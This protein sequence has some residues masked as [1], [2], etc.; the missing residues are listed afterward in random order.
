MSKRHIHHPGKRV[1]AYPG[2]RVSR[3]QKTLSKNLIAG[4]AVI[5]LATL[6]LAAKTWSDL[7]PLPATLLSADVRKP[8][9][10]DRNGTPLNITYQNRWNVHDYIELHEMPQFLQQ[11][12][13]VAEDK[14]FFEHGGVDWLARWHAAW[15]NMKALRGVRGASTITEQSVRMIHQRPRTLWSR[16][17]EGFEA[18]QLEKQ[19]SKAEILEFYLNQ[20]PYTAKRRGVAQA[21]RYY[22]DRSP[23]TLS[24]KEMM[25]LAVLVRSPSRLDLYRDPARVDGP[26]GRLLDQ[27]SRQGVLSARS[28]R[29]IAVSRLRLSGVPGLPVDASHFVRYVQRSNNAPARRLATTLDGSLQRHAQSV[30]DGRIRALRR[31]GVTHGA[32]LAV[33]HRSDEVLVWVNGGSEKSDIDAVLTLRQPGSALKPFVYA[34]ALEKGWT[35]ATLINDSPLTQSVGYGLHRYQNYSRKHYGAVRLRD[36]L[37]NSLN[38]PAVRA[39]QFVGPADVLAGFRRLGMDNLREHPDFYGDGIA[40]GNGEVSLLELVRAYAVLARQGVYRDLRT[41]SA[42]V[43]SA[44]RRVFSP[45]ASALIANILADP[46]ARSLEFGHS[47]LLNLPIQTAVKTGTSSDFRDAWTVGF[48]HRYVVGVWMGN[49]DYRAMDGITG[50]R[51]PASVMRAVFAELNRGLE[52]RPLKLSAKLVK[53]RIC[54]DSGRAANDLCA[55]RSEWFTPGTAP[56]ASDPARQQVERLRLRQ[57][58]EGLHLAMDPRIPDRLEAF[59]L[60]LPDTLAPHKVEWWVDDIVYGATGNGVTRYPWRLSRGRHTARARVWLSAVAR[61]IETPSVRFEV[62]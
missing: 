5:A 22:F 18:A 54:R 49:L 60:A 36:A 17:L 32:V 34:L 27:M 55:S 35:A 16:W 51:G 14:R 6:I 62:K 46:D 38:I 33:D 4:L 29:E 3:M 47:G 12:F 50:S 24:K 43:A 53:A 25:A 9:I 1:S 41:R 57:P 42:G 10:L 39:A 20:V 21:A 11:A 30:L 58:V 28:Y 19:F 8:Q 40:L 52:T 7:R 61:P 45:G 13:V 59:A 31:R 23:D 44:A 56:T 37:G 26:L 2:S 48:N 15:Q